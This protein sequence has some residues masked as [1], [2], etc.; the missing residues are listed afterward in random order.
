MLLAGRVAD[1]TPHWQVEQTHTPSCAERE[2]FVDNLLVRIHVIIETLNPQPYTRCATHRSPSRASPIPQTLTEVQGYLNCQ[3]TP[4]P[5]GPN[6]RPVPRVLGESYRGGRFLM[7]EVA[8]YI[9]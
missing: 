6:R 8:L 1:R 5:L 3:K 4:P 2:S 7:G 9:Y